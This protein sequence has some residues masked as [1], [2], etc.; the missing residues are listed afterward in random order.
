VGQVNLLGLYVF[1]FS[2]WVQ[3]PAK[4]M[5]AGAGTSWTWC[6]MGWLWDKK[7]FV[8]VK[9][10]P[11]ACK[12]DMSKKFNVTESLWYKSLATFFSGGKTTDWSFQLS[13]SVILQEKRSG[14]WQLA[15]LVNKCEYGW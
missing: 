9:D 11:G 14:L 2:G 6:K 1:T 13:V 12:S 5:C 15:L 7:F 4:V 8:Q 3:E 10:W